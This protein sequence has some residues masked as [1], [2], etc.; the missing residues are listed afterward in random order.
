MD[1]EKINA[2]IENNRTFTFGG[3]FN[4]DHQVEIA[5]GQFEVSSNMAKKRQKAYVP[6]NINLSLEGHKVWF[7]WMT[8]VEG[9]V[10]FVMSMNEETD[11]RRLIRVT[12]ERVE[13]HSCRV[14]FQFFPKGT[15]KEMIERLYT[16][17]ESVDW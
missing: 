14:L 15:T 6:F 16:N 5:R 17:L 2:L 1:L 9:Y 11:T 12:K 10:A 8:E 7:E 13:E 4:I 3:G